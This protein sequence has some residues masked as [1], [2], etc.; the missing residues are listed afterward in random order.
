MVCGVFRRTSVDGLE[1]AIFERKE[2]AVEFEFPGGKIDPG[3]SE[4][5]ALVRELDE[6]LSVQVTVGQKI[7]EVIYD[8]PTARIDL[9]AYWVD[10]TSFDFRLVDH[11]RWTWVSAKN[12]QTFKVAGPDIPLL[13]TIFSS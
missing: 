13:K 3:E 5:Q 8:Y 1:V 6:E 4:E 2:P 11:F 12:W 10:S 9:R 7:G